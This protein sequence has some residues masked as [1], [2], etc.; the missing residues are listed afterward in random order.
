MMICNDKSPSRLDARGSVVAWDRRLNGRL[1]GVIS[2]KNCRKVQWLR[3]T[4][5]SAA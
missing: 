1:S 2:Y 5:D 4:C 3:T